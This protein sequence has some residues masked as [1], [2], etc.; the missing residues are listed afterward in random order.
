MHRIN[1]FF[2]VLGSV[3]WG[4]SQ[5]GKPGLQ[6][7]TQ[8]ANFLIN[9]DGYMSLSSYPDSCDLMPVMDHWNVSHPHVSLRD[10]MKEEEALQNNV[11]KV[12]L[13]PT[14]LQFAEFLFYFDIHSLMSI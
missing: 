9:T 6:D 7:Q 1:H 3:H 12:I 8:S 14:V 2:C 4:D 11:E 5:A 10:I 13:A